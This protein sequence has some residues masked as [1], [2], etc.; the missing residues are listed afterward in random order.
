[1]ILTIYIYIYIYSKR[2][3]F[4]LQGAGCTALLVAVVS[5]KLE[6]TRAEKHLK[7]AAANVLRETWLI[8]KHTRLVKRVNPGRVRT[9]QRKFL[10]AIYAL[11]KVKMDQRKLMDNA[12][13]ITDMAKVSFIFHLLLIQK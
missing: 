5:R 10:L 4:F 6:L 11:R 9:H 7:N 13:T 2:F 3:L 12:N 1:M 8:Y